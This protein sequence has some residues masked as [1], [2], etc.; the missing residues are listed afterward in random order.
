MERVNTLKTGLLKIVKRKDF[1]VIIIF[2][3]MFI[4]AASLENNF[5]TSGAIVRNI[6]AF[7]P[8]ILMAMGQAIVLI[9]G[10]VDLSC[11]ALLSLQNCVLTYVMQAD[12]P[13]TGIYALIITFLISVGVGVLNGVGV[14][15]FRIPPIV[16]TF[17]TSFMCL[18]IALFIRPT[19]G[20]QVTNWFQFF[21]NPSLVQGMPEGIA[22]AGKVFS[23]ALFLVLGA[24][25]LWFLV[26][27]TKTGR[28]MYAV[29][30]NRD[31]A[32]ASGIN[33]AEIQI[34][35]YVLNAIFI[36]LAGIFFSAQN[37]SGDARM[38]DPMTLRAIAS[39]VVGGVALTGGRG[40]VYFAIMGAL[41]MSFVNK[42]IYFA[43]V[44]T[45]YQTFAGGVII[46]LAIS[47]STIYTI[48]GKRMAAGARD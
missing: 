12:Q 35:A 1:S 16:V 41:T 25:G 42:V 23:P 13:V 44:P 29:G 2:A 22:A 45:A 8:L 4:I 3:I 14:G 34:K 38:G 28:Y 21:Y 15:V 19:P 43:N 7:S 32:Y 27:K 37:L 47:T 48:A 30:S 46:L 40:N 9:T 31:N 18:G 39:A 20:G 6:N 36:M 17:A 24:C 10:G 33:T 5:F 26:S 11:G